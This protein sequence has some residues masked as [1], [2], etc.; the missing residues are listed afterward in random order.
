MFSRAETQSRVCSSCNIEKPITEFHKRGAGVQTSCK[1]CK[2]R[3]ARERYAKSGRARVRPVEVKP[4][5]VENFQELSARIENLAPRLRSVVALFVNNPMDADD[6]FQ[7]ITESILRSCKPE[8]TDSY[9]LKKAKFF[10][11]DH[12]EKRRTYSH[13]VESVQMDRAPESLFSCPASAEDEVIERELS[14]ELKSIISELP[15][16]NQKVV[17][18][19][20]LGYSQREIAAKMETTEQNISRRMKDIRAR[21]LHAGAFPSFQPGGVVSAI[22]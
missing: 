10:S 8:D 7:T 14:D 20:T 1:E 17:T 22:A 15:P 5:R 2:C 16:Q 4:V 3:A 11:A 12:L 19:L 21:F 13:R 6:M 9:I 18:L